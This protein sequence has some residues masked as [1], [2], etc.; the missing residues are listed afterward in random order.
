MNIDTSLNSIFN[1]TPPIEGEFI[2][3]I[4]TTDTNIPEDKSLTSDCD[5]VRSNLYKLLEISQDALEESL[6]IAKQSEAPRAFEVVSNMIKQISDVNMQILD[7]HAKKQKLIIPEKEINTTTNI[8]NNSV[9]CGTSKD[10]NEMINK[11]TKG[12]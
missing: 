9:F 5:Q 7:I 1:L 8:T 10:L 4:R 12:T 2:S 3:N 6:E 11:L